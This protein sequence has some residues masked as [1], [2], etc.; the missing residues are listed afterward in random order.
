M[1]TPQTITTG[2]V[3]GRDI[4]P[5][6]KLPPEIRNTVYGY[7]LVHEVPIRVRVRTAGP[8]IA[9]AIQVK[10]SLYTRDQRGRQRENQ[11][12][13]VSFAG[14]RGTG[15]LRTN[16]IISKEALPV[17]YGQNTFSFGS[18][19]TL[20]DFMKQAKTGWNSLRLVRLSITGHDNN[21]GA[22]AILRSAKSMSRLEWCISGLRD[23]LE[24]TIEAMSQALFQFCYCAPAMHGWRTR[25]GKVEFVLEPL[26]RRWL[27]W[28]LGNDDGSK[29][30]KLLGLL[31]KKVK[32]RL[33][34][35]WKARQASLERR[36]LQ[37]R[38]GG[39]RT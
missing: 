34:E 15:L 29:V 31:G 18:A 20:R 37:A 13:W 5:F 3:T 22:M 23:P 19:W 4:F 8:K 24:E 28:D 6:Q 14:E 35:A 36:L 33:S 39:L 25:F 10:A 17:L 32:K 16:K 38:A 30:T 2:N 9:A 7:A 11:M 12:I 1:P 21:R 27:A 26:E